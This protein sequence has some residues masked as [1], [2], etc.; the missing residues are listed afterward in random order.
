[1]SISQF[2]Q[3]LANLPPSQ[4][5]KCDIQV[6]IGVKKT[7]G[8][9]LNEL[10]IQKIDANSM[11]IIFNQ[12]ICK[13]IEKQITVGQLA[14]MC[15][16]LIAGQDIEELLLTNLGELVFSLADMKSFIYFNSDTHP[17]VKSLVSE[18]TQFFITNIKPSLGQSR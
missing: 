15:E 11:P 14:G 2:R 4:P 6:I 17:E 5:Q 12:L 8:E 3:A 1:M 7:L 9:V 16:Y 18:I 10:H 13:F